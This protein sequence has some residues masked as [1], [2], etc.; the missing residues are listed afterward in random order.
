MPT[1]IPPPVS[2][3]GFRIAI[4]CALPEE[5][6]AVEAV[7]TR[8]YKED[9]KRTYGKAK[10]DD[11]HYTL[12]EL[13]DKPVVVVTPRNMGTI[14]TANLAKDMRHSFP[15][16]AYALVVGVAGGAPFR[17]SGGKREYSDIQL[18][19]VVISTQVVGYDFGAEYDNDFQSK[20]AVEDTLPR[21]PPT[22]ANFMNTL[23]TRS[24]RAYKR[25]LETTNED[26]TPWGPEYARPDQ[27]LD[28]VYLSQVR[29]KHQD[30]Q[31]CQVCAK[32]TDWHH[33]VC[34]D[35]L[36]T[37]CD[38]LGC[39]PERINA[40]RETR[41]HFGRIASGNAVMKSARRRDKL[42]QEDR[43]IGFEMESAGTWETFGTIVVKGVVDYADSHK[44]KKW[45]L[46]PAARAALCA[47]ALIKEIELP[48]VPTEPRTGQQSSKP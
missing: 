38:Q 32:C 1:S 44:N 47:K 34:E 30:P 10:N 13:G 48:D 40:P 31:K 5:R 27:E 2:R 46:Y 25:V 16:I 42:I 15:N 9:D 36:K 24:S 43:C 3:D 29:H 22:I 14:N 37:T 39:A 17:F 19:D 45:R 26:L 41:I 11:N 28:C 7:L 20:T 35:A 33:P 21:A 23:C 8:D 4:I 12:G 18:G 6:D